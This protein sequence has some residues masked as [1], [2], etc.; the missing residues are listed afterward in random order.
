MCK[1]VCT[2]PS[3]TFLKYIHRILHSASSLTFITAF[4]IKTANL[5]NILSRKGSYYSF[6]IKTENLASTVELQW[7]EN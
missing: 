2:F 1:K 5:A 3:D 6:N 4:S 7:L